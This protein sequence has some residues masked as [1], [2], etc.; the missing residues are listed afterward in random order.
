V[1]TNNASAYFMKVTSPTKA[2]KERA[3]KTLFEQRFED[4]LECIKTS[5]TKKS[6]VKTYEKVVERIGR[7]K[8]KYPSAHSRYKIEIEKQVV[9]ISR[10]SNSAK[11]KNAAVTKPKE[12]CTSLKWGKI[13]KLDAQ[14]Q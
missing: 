7:L 6:G 2:M 4:G 9:P 5:L 8:Q 3:L 12:I 1:L 10:T 11:T 14:K 13:A